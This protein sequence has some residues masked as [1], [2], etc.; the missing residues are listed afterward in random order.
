[1]SR[2]PGQWSLRV[3]SMEDQFETIE[4]PL[5]SLSFDGYT[6]EW[7]SDVNDAEER[8]RSASFNF[9]ILDQRV[10][11]P[12]GGI[13]FSAGSSLAIKLKSGELGNT[14]VHIPFVFVTGSDDWV[15]EGEMAKLPGYRGILV[16]ASDV[17]TKLRAYCAQ[18]VRRIEPSAYRDRVLVRVERVSRTGIEVVIPSWSLSQEVYVPVDELPEGV[19]VERLTGARLFARMDLSVR[20]SDGI[21]LDRWELDSLEEDSDGPT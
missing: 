10:E 20:S 12:G 5:D 11:K 17:T 6:V 14:N 2:D 15:E 1:M 18:A 4:G 7:S 21:E 3:L 16:K 8:L 13:D 19:E 9:L